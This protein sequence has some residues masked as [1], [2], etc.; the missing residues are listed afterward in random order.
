MA[1]RKETATRASVTPRLNASAPERASSTIASATACGS[2]SRRGP[3]SSEPAYQA[4]ISSTSEMSRAPTLIPRGRPVERA[5]RKLARWADQLHAGDLGKDEVE[6]TCV[7]FFFGKGPAHDA[8]AVALAID[9]KRVGVD[10]ANAPRKSLPFGL[11]RSEDFFRLTGGVEKAVDGGSVARGPGTVEGIADDRDR[12]LGAEALHDTVHGDGALEPFAFELGAEVP[13][14]QGGVDLALQ[15]L[16]RQQRRRAVDDRRLLAEIDAG[17]P[18]Q[19]LQQEP[20]LV[21]RAARNGELLALEIGDVSDGRLPR[22]HDGAERARRRMEDQAV[23]ERALPRHPQPV[24]E[25]EIGRA[26]LERDLAGLGRG[27]LDGLDLEIEPAIEAM[28]LDDVEL[29]RQRP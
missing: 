3:A 18:R 12:P 22:H 19:C 14:G 7:G 17:A 15:R 21:E 6:G 26:A 9:C 4:A 2:G 1:M 27:E 20:A 11:R 23:A 25:H 13:E 10:G 8:F 24:R 5:G 29:P 28:R 16:L